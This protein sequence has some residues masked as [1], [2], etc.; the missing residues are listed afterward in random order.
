MALYRNSIHCSVEGIVLGG[1]AHFR[2]PAT[3]DGVVSEQM[4]RT[5]IQG[6]NVKKALRVLWL[7]CCLSK[8]CKICI[9]GSACTPSQEPAS[10]ATANLEKI[11][12]GTI[13][14]RMKFCETIY[15]RTK[16]KKLY[17]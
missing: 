4:G 9:L 10:R 11:V 6:M 5:L 2:D 1:R 15:R 3:V 8:D 7:S 12:T 16:F 17:V 13:T 14:D